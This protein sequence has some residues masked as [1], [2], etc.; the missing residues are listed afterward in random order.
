MADEWPKKNVVIG[1][2]EVDG[3]LCIGNRGWS[4]NYPENTVEA[5]QSA[6]E[7]G[8][9]GSLIDVQLTS[10]GEVVI[11][12]D[13]LDRTT[14]GTGKVSKRPWH[15][16]I[17]SLV[18]SKGALPVPRLKDMLTL[19]T[20]DDTKDV[21]VL[22]DIKPVNGPKI[23]P[24]IAEIIKS[25]KY[26]FRTQVQ[27]GVWTT[28]Y[29]DLV[30]KHLPHILVTHIGYDLKTSRQTYPTVD[31][32]SMYYPSVVEDRTGFIRHIHKKDKSIYVWLLNDEEDMENAMDSIGVDGIIS[33]NPDLCLDVRRSGLQK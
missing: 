25:F 12:N 13:T 1:T 17:D 31:I 11:I 14:N 5:V 26:E 9:D 22:L 32:F 19:L 21:F 7:L 15:G 28:E 27:L 10:D 23:I 20:Q 3:I 18:T 30:K 16:Y 8:A 6:F 4:S 24:K 29:F 2:A 33:D